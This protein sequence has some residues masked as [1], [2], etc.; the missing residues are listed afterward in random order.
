MQKPKILVLRRDNIGDLI[1]TLPLVAALR[2]LLPD[3]RIDLLVNSYCVSLVEGNTDVNHVFFYTKAKH[4]KKGESWLSVYT[5]RFLLTLRLRLIRYDFLVLANVSCLPR[6]LRWAKQ[7]GAKRVIGFIELGNDLGGSVISDPIP[8]FRESAKHEVEYL[9]ALL[10]PFGKVD[11]FPKAVVKPNPEM[12]LKAQKLL[13]TASG[14]KPI[15]G[16]NISARLLTQR[17][18]TERF[19][20]LICRLVPSFRCVLFWSPGTDSSAG[21]PG[22]DAK[23]S[24]ILVATQ[25]LDV[26]GYPT[27][28]LS[29]LIAAIDCVD[30]FVSPDG[31][32]LHIGAACGKPTI[33]LFGEANPEQWYPWRVNHLILRPTTRNLA[34]LS[35]DELEYAC[36]SMLGQDQ[37]AISQP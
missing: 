14:I 23:A 8:L 26:I 10:G 3:A 19:I 9:M 24:E 27:L 13:K 34:D 29:E 4:R 16:I 11:A 20:E 15:I 25:E 12:R 35:V 1:C 5:K 36:L 33:A 32:A 31:G 17:W 6:P 2:Q 22:D 21:H 28:V 18:P 37:N 7:I 30:L